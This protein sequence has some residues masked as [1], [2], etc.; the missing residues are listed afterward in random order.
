MTHCVQ[1]C[2]LSQNSVAARARSWRGAGAGLARAPRPNLQ[3]KPRLPPPCEGAYLGR[4]YILAKIKCMGLVSVGHVMNIWHL[5]GWRAAL[6]TF[7]NKTCESNAPRAPREST[8]ANKINPRMQPLAVPEIASRLLHLAIPRIAGRLLHLAVPWITGR[9]L[10]SAVPWIA[11]RLLHSAV[12]W[13]AG[14]LLH[15]AVPWIAARLLHS[16]VPWIAA[17]LLHLAAPWVAGRLLHLA[18]RCIDCYCTWRSMA[19]AVTLRLA[20]CVI[21]V[22]LLPALPAHFPNVCSR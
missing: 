15:S 2:I 9:L 16:A 18:V 8:L 7:W 5:D 4:P 12:P 19:S 11:G 1:K 21:A 3:F 6:A 14:R 13:I 10:H 20:V 17:R 22:H